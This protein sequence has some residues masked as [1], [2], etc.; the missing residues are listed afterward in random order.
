MKK[1]LSFLF[2]FISTLLYSQQTYYVTPSGNAGNSGASFASPKSLLNALSIASAGDEVILQSGTYNIPYSAGS[3]NTIYLTQSGTAG[4]NIYVHSE[5]N[6]QATIDFQFPEY[7]WVQDSYGFDITGDYWKFKGLI[8]TRA[9]YQG[10]YCKGGY[11][12]FEYCIFYDN[13]NSGM[14]VNKT[15]HHTTLLNCDAYHNYDPKKGGQMADGFAVKQTQGAG[16]VLINCRSWDNSDDAYDTYDSPDAVVFRNCWAFDNGYDSW[17]DPNIAFDGNGN[18]FKVGGN[19]KLQNNILSHCVSFGHPGK[20]FDQNNNTG[21]ITLFNCTSYD[22]GINYGMGGSLAGGEQH[23]VRNCI[24]LNSGGSNS[25]GSAAQSNNSWSSGFSVGSGDFLSLNVA[26]ADDARNSD[27]S[28]PD[29]DLFRLNSSS[30]LVD[31]GV[32]VG[33]VYNGSAPDLGAFETGADAPTLSSP[34]NK[35]QTVATGTAIVPVV[36]TWGGTATGVTVSVLPAGLTGTTNSAAKTYTITG[37]PTAAGTYTVTTTQASGTAASNTGTITLSL[38]TPIS[39]SATAASNSITVNWT[40]ATGATGYTVNVC[41]AGVGVLQ[42]WDWTGAWTIGAGDA[43]ANLEEDT[44]PGRFNYLPATTNGALVFANSNPI[45]D[46]QDLLFTQGGINKIRLGYNLGKLYLNGSGLSITIPCASGNKITLVSQAGNSLAT[47]RGYSVAGGTLN[48]TESSANVNASGILTEA[49]GTGTWVYDATSSA[50][51]ITSVTGGMN[52]FSISVSGS[53]GVC[54]EYTVAGGTT[55]SY[56][57]TGLDP[58]TEYTYQVK[59]TNGTPALASAYSTEASINTLALTSAPTLTDPGNKIQSV[60]D[61]SAIS[62]IVFTWGGGATDVS[63]SGLPAGLTST[64]N[65]GAK[66]LTITGTPTADGTY[67]VTT[68]GGTGAPVSV[69]GTITVLAN[70][71]TLST[72]LNKTQTVNDGTAISTVVF[73]WGGGATDVSI[74]SLPAGLSSTKNVGAKTV[75]ITGIP[76]AD[77]TYTVTTIGGTGASVAIT[78]IITVLPVAGCLELITIPIT[79]LVSTGNYDIILFDVAGTTQIRDLGS[80]EFNVGDS[81]FL[82]PRD[83]LSAGTYTF[84]VMNGATVL[85]TGGILLP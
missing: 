4:A 41:E 57:V 23:E 38:A 50:V 47:D 74:A 55:S 45:P 76:T 27:G 22:N 77:G 54:T 52:P 43:D 10:V 30:D 32:D 36:F 42:S 18:G 72:P 28:L 12:T 26:L 69:L 17:S 49:A 46:T 58:E 62:T 85:K 81:N 44:T 37:I 64:K 19:Y 5:V 34:S 78:G 60:I 11:N 83:G 13:R 56:T 65:A 29:N 82:F 40:P 66:T 59:A 35:T 84:K 33:L 16:N 31:A 15:G 6:T 48:T 79:A 1:F 9:G 51:T 2:L 67:T 8:I 20:G 61:G 24:S 25:F 14:E 39:V 21:G 80:G 53:G 3:K 73:T 68:I 70:N 75:T 71:P 7:E 63:I